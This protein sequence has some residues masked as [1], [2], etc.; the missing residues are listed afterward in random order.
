MRSPSI[1][2]GDEFSDQI[3]QMLVTNY[4]HVIQ[5]F[6]TD[7]AYPA[8]RDRVSLGSLHRSANLL[9]PKRSDSPI[10]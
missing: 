2:I 7:G 8:F 9:Y 10:E 1:V 6:V 5:A 3:P 4:E